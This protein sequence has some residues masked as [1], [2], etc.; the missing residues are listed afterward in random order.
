MS[1]E[2]M[3]ATVRIDAPADAVFAVLADPASHA[4]IDGTGWVRD[5]VDGGQ[6]ITAEGQVFQVAMYHAAHPDGDYQMAN[7]VVAYDRPRAIAWEPGQYD[8]DGN[9]GL[10]GWVW[11]YDLQAVGATPN[12]ATQTEVTLTYDWS[13]VSAATREVIPFPPFDSEHLERSL[14]HLA[15]LVTRGG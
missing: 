8:P 12:G 2:T 14:A 9:L 13:R 4:A 15:D 1:D 5:P 3:I 7:K 10:G 6:P 11:R